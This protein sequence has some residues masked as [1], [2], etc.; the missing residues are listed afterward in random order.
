MSRNRRGG[1]RRPSDTEIAGQQVTAQSGAFVVRLGAASTNN[2]VVHYLEQ[3]A[4]IPSKALEVTISG[5]LR[6][7]TQEPADDVYDV[8]YVRLFEES[9]PASNFFR[10]CPL[11]EPDRR[12]R[13]DCVLVPRERGVDR[14]QADGIPGR[15]RPG[16]QRPDLL[17][18]RYAVDRGHPLLAIDPVEWG[19]GESTLKREWRPNSSGLKTG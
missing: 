13:L 5:Y 2:Y 18:L 15:R 16:H 9:M 6:V 14:R 3:Y 19:R 10:T 17:L 1:I 7:R 4:T 11:V 8:A 12:Q